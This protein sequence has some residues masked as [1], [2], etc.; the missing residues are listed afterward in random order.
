LHHHQTAPIVRELGRSGA[1][2]LGV[3]TP[4]RSIVPYTHCGSRIDRRVTL[5]L[6]LLL[7]D[8]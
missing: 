8:G 1:K 5:G 7:C 3:L 6:L 4:V 2:S